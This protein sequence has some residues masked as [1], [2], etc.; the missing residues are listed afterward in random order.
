MNTL[1]RIFYLQSKVRF[2]FINSID[3]DAFIDKEKRKVERWGRV[4]EN[5][6]RLLEDKQ[7]KMAKAIKRKEEHEKSVSLEKKQKDKEIVNPKF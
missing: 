6:N 3:K 4:K 5:F 1:S 7:K 2:P